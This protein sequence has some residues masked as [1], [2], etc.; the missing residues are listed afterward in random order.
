MHQCFP[1]FSH[2]DQPLQ[3]L[4]ELVEQ[5][6]PAIKTLESHIKCVA[7]LH[8]P[9]LLY[10]NTLTSS[11]ND[12]IISCIPITSRQFFFRR[13][14]EFTEQDPQNRLA[15]NIFNFISKDLSKETKTF[16]NYPM[17]NEEEIP[18]VKVEVRPV[19]A[20]QNG[21]NSGTSRNS[22][23][24]KP[25]SSCSSKGFDDCHYPLGRYCGITKLSS[26]EILQVMKRVN[27]CFTCG[28][29]HSSNADCNSTFPN[30]S[31]KA[32]RKG[33]LHDGVPV[34]LAICKHMI[35]RRPSPSPR[36][37]ILTIKSIQLDVQY[38]MGCQINLITT[39]ALKLLP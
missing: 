9:V 2:L 25:C 37:Y 12:T 38:D 34:N 39:S 26:K 20:Q 30:G 32:C 13:L 17:D 11:L 16:N 23:Q 8:N 28:F 24:R 3:G 36:W 33:C 4:Q 22:F 6:V 31:P 14:Q 5:L 10:N 1:T 7:T 19:R 29:Q 27:A 15:P 18:A 21:F 35:S